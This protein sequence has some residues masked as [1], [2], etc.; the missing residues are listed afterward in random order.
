MVVDYFK[1]SVAEGARKVISERLWCRWEGGGTS[2]A[3]D[4]AFLHYAPGVY[5]RTQSR[6]DKDARERPWPAS[7]EPDSG[8]WRREKAGD[9]GDMSADSVR[10]PQDGREKRTLIESESPRRKNKGFGQEYFYVHYFTE[11]VSPGGW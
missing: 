3:P 6:R 7:S 5:G 11:G 4:V 9:C 8:T 1:V 2:Q 10:G